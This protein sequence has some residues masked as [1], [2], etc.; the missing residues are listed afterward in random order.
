M[1]I[2]TIEAET[3]NIMVHGT[4]KEAEAV[5]GAEHFRNEAGL[6]KLAANWPA[7]RLVEIWNSLPGATPVKKFKDRNTAA[8]RI[9]KSI[10]SLGQTT[11]EQATEPVE[12]VVE[13]ADTAAP[14]APQ[15]PNVPPTKAPSE[16]RAT[17]SEK[18][19]PSRSGSQSSARR[20]QIGHHSGTAA[21]SRRDDVECTDGSHRL[22]G[23]FRSRIP[24]WHDPQEDGAQRGIDQGRGWNA[25]LL[26]DGLN[27][28]HL[29]KS[30]PLSFRPA[31]F[32]V[33]QDA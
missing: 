19:A 6:A 9:W 18:G 27:H 23:A 25:E 32:F 11:P 5:A 16:K 22:A 30:S 29:S 8:A 15:T 24:L 20:Q 14:D 26:R 12:P 13:P 28:L 21:G 7:N 10:Q 31:A 1:K 17:R 3:N 4:M 33:S 2:F